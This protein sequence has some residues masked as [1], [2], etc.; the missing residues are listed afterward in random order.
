M[1]KVSDNKVSI[2]ALTLG[3]TVLASQNFEAVTTTLIVLLI[4]SLL[5]GE[6]FSIRQN[7]VNAYAS[8]ITENKVLLILLKGAIFNFILCFLLALYLSVALLIKLHLSWYA[9]FIFGAVISVMAFFEGSVESKSGDIFKEQVNHSFYRIMLMF[10]IVFI[11]SVMDLSVSLLTQY[12]AIGSLLDVNIPSIVIDEVQHK[13]KP[14]QDM[15]RTFHYIDLNV[16][17]IKH[18][19]IDSNTTSTIRALYSLSTTPYVAMMLIYF[20]FSNLWRRF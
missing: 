14:L 2:I 1:K 4:V 20:S 19:D 9:I 15:L 3:L 17:S 10:I 8:V 18:A 11:C 6:I 7:I 13:V 5:T 12:S 16:H